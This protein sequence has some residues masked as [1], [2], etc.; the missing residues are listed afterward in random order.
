M[1]QNDTGL[2]NDT[3]TKQYLVKKRYMLQNSTLQ[4]ST[5]QNV[6]VTKRYIPKGYTDIHQLIDW[7]GIYPNQP[8]ITR[9]MVSYNKKNSINP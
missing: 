6:T 5:I 2:Q 7:W 8:N 9:D 4:N 1:L 3:V